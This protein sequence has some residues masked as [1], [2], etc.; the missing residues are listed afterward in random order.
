MR[1]IERLCTT[2]PI[3]IVKLTQKYRQGMSSEELYEASRQYWVVGPRRAKVKYV[4]AAYLGRTIEAYLVENW[5]AV[6]HQ[7]KTRWAFNGVVAN[8]VVSKKLVNKSIWHLHVKGA[9]NPVR[10]L[11]C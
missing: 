2:E 3:L 6:L 7:G 10:Y 5:Y 8:D 9:A 4:V 11:N 1:E